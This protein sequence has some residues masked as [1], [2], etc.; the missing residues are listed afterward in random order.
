L[1]IFRDRKRAVKEVKDWLSRLHC[2]V[3]G[4]GMERNPTIIENVKGVLE[5]AKEQGKL[6]VIDAV[7]HTFMIFSNCVFFAH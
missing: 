4:P 6:I 1:V 3:F 5:L 2:L 7:E